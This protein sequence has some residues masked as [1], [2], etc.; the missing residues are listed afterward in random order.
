MQDKFLYPVTTK[1]FTAKH[2]LKSFI[3][4]FANLAPYFTATFV[5][6]KSDWLSIKSYCHSVQFLL[7][8]LHVVTD[9]STL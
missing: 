5:S 8:S 4:V 1:Q 9:S 2:Y 7:A 3:D 6:D